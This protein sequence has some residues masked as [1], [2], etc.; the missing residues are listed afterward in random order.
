MQCFLRVIALSTAAFVLVGHAASAEERDLA[1]VHA[2]QNSKP[3]LGDVA[4]DYLQALIKQ[5]D[6]PAEVRD[7]FDLEMSKSLRV[8][9]QN[10][11]DPAERA[12]MQAKSQ[13]YLDRFIKAKPNHPE[14]VQAE[15]SSAEMMFE[16]GKESWITGRSLKEKA[17]RDAKLTE[18][19]KAYEQA[20]PLFK[21]VVN[22][23]TERLTKIPPPQRRAPGASQ[24]K[25]DKEAAATRA[26]IEAALI[27]ARGE[28]ALLDYFIA[29][30]YSEPA[31]INKRKTALSTAAKASSTQ[32]S[33]C[34]AAT[35]PARPTAAPR[36]G[37]MSGTAR[38]SR[39]SAIPKRPTT[40]TKKCWATC[41]T[42]S[43]AARRVSPAWKTCSPRP[44]TSRSC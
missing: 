25:A 10:I 16:Q 23:L 3:P 26:A 31:D 1:F 35:I 44:R 5:P 7:V 18:A 11:A 37:P 19:R 17:D 15:L 38:P 36:F 4:A 20:G 32:F 8:Q 42:R 28:A 9:S 12:A 29:Q 6:C 41:P 40:S 39:S 27:R 22:K 14:A 34:T 21:Q 43:T 13:E 24:T 2:L 30:T 33:N